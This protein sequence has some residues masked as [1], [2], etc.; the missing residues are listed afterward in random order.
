MRKWIVEFFRKFENH[1]AKTARV[2]VILI[3]ES[4]NFLFS[5]LILYD[6][7][8]RFDRR[9]FSVLSPFI[10]EKSKVF[11]ILLFDINTCIKSLSLTHYKRLNGMLVLT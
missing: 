3:T 1:G 2:N 8:V 4:I 6:V 7:G 11:S 9:G 5:T 10:I